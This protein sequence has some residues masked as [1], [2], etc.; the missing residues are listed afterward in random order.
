[1][2]IET[3]QSSAADTPLGVMSTLRH[4]GQLQKPF[5]VGRDAASKLASEFV[6]ASIESIKPIFGA[7]EKVAES[8]VFGVGEAAL[9]QNPYRAFERLLES[10]VGL[11]R[12]S[13]AGLIGASSQWAPRE[14]VRI[15]PITGGSSATS[16]MWLH[17]QGSATHSCEELLV[18]DLIGHGGGQIGAEYVHIASQFV[19]EV[20]ARSSRAVTIEVHVPV[21]TASDTYRGTILARNE[22]LG[23]VP[24]EVL[25]IPRGR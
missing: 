22:P 17:N 12:A 20:P 4:L 21:C 5:D 25:V 10:I 19:P 11:G 6:N 8:T 2:T 9:D 18:S 23:W 24:I 3:S 15:G 14:A 7:E 1:M 13:V 16:Q